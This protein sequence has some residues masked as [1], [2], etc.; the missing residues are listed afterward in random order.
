MTFDDQL[1]RA[2]DTLTDRLR[3]EIDGLLLAVA[4]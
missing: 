3:D 4:Q 2:F 1:Q